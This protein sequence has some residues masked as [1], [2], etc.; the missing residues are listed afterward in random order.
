MQIFGSSSVHNILKILIHSPILKFSGDEIYG[1]HNFWITPKRR[2]RRRHL[3][4]P[5]KEVF[6]GSVPASNIFFR[7]PTYFR[8]AIRT[9]RKIHIKWCRQHRCRPPPDHF[10]NGHEDHNNELFYITF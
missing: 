9:S 1:S 7:L 4:I 8:D 6:L 5:Q 10:A 2:R 3:G